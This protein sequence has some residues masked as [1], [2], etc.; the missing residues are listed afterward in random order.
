MERGW[1][2][3][4]MESDVRRATTNL[5]SGRLVVLGLKQKQPTGLCDGASQAEVQERPAQGFSTLV[6]VVPS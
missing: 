2:S 5:S 1:K 3:A 4:G 6:P